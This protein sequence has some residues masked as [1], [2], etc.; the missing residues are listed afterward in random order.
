[1]ETEKA[2]SRW[3]LPHTV[4]MASEQKAI[5]R[6]GR[7]AEDELHNPVLTEQAARVETFITE[8]GI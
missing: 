8:K 5:C 6:C 7:K 4:E 3:D 1:M 2:T